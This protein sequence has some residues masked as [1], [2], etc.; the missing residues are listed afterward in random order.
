MAAVNCTKINETLK[1]GGNCSFF[2]W[3]MLYHSDKQSNCNAEPYTGSVC[4]QQLMAL[5]EC[6]IGSLENVLLDLTLME[7]SLEEKERDVAQFLHFLCELL[8]CIYVG[9]E[10]SLYQM[11]EY[12]VTASLGSDD[13]QRA[14]GMLVCLSSFP[15][16]DECQS[17][18]SYMSSRGECERISMVECKE[19]WTSAREYGISLPNCTD[20][21]EELIGENSTNFAKCHSEL[22]YKHVHVLH[23]NTIRHADS[24]RRA[25]PA[26]H[27]CE[28]YL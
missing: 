27:F 23:N 26:C 1:V 24:F 4:S 19:E 18:H 8:V 17:G 20:L 28:N 2:T 22:S 13:C 10:H 5:Q 9:Y 3:E 15:L 11:H 21:P 16:C 7:K 12:A 25:F 14:A 6:I